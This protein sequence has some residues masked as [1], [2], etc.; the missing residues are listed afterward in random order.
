M[1]YVLINKSDTLGYSVSFPTLSNL[2]A[3][4]QNRNVDLRHI[5]NAQELADH[6]LPLRLG[7][8]LT[9]IFELEIYALKAGWME[10]FD[11]C[12]SKFRETL[13]MQQYKRPDL[14]WMKT[15]FLH[16]FTYLYGKESFDYDTE[17]PDINKVLDEGKEFGGYDSVTLWHQYPRLGVDRR[18][19]WDFFEDFP[20]GLT[21]L[22][23]TVDAVHNQK[24]RVFLPYKPWDVGP[25]ESM[26]NICEKLSHLI[27]KSGVDGLFLD[28][29]T[30][31]PA[32]FR[33]TMDAVHPGLVFISEGYPESHRA[34]EVLTGSW[35]QYFRRGS[36]LEVNCLRFAVPEHNFPVINRW[37][38]GEEKD[39]MLLRAMFSGSGLVIWQDVF[40]TWLPFTPEQ[41][42]RIFRYK[43]I[44]L[45]D[46]D[47]FMGGGAIPLLPTGHESL[48]CN[49]FASDTRRAFIFTLY[50][51]SGAKTE[52][53]L[54]LHPLDARYFPG[55]KQNHGDKKPVL[56]V[57][58]GDGTIAITEKYLTGELK[59]KEFAMIKITW[60]D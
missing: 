40:G 30:T 49:M 10:T 5:A 59:P 15:L 6:R 18:S 23:E 20:G 44:W 47:I 8:T 9:D 25:G 32:E 13:D 48:F 26:N 31:I 22:R 39:Q 17:R 43:E 35:E 55:D 60:E 4:V 11:R 34:L 58:L 19:Q 29:M 33:R 12:R 50:N 7:R 56:S 54:L 52:G 21:G 53:N 42:E 28:T 3:A 46:Q 24:V 38:L 41:K 2:E 27:T 36:G 51:H 37:A 57:L 16:H 14:D 45:R 1:P